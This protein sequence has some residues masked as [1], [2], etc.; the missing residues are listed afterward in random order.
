MLVNH[1]ECDAAGLLK[2]V[3]EDPDIRPTFGKSTTTLDELIRPE[4]QPRPVWLQTRRPM[5]WPL[6]WSSEF[7]TQIGGRFGYR[8]V[9]PI[10]TLQIG[11]WIAA[12][13]L[14]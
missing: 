3:P 6:T 10:L 4:I 12:L 7:P 5:A 14:V 13:D 8:G 2:R 11:A 1:I 9:E